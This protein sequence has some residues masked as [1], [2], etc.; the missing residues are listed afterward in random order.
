MCGRRRS[1]NASRWGVPRAL[2]RSPDISFDF[3]S[4]PRYF[5]ILGG[6]GGSTP[7]Q[8][9]LGMVT[10]ISSA[11][12]LVC[13]RLEGKQ[14]GGGDNRTW[15]LSKSNLSI[16]WIGGGEG[17]LSKILGEKVEAIY[18]YFRSGRCQWQSSKILQ[19]LAG[20][21]LGVHCIIEIPKIETEGI[22]I[23]TCQGFDGED[24]KSLPETDIQ[25]PRGHLRG[26]DSFCT[27]LRCFE[28]SPRLAFRENI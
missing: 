25:E 22:F 4:F 12:F 5:E 27:F 15:T 10:Q 20:R 26:G 8:T 14:P 6:D 2:F 17:S 18:S 21:A 11:L 24:V 13:T 19:I 16:W 23:E 7:S 3:A 9:L 28:D 1:Q